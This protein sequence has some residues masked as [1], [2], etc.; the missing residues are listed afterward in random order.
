MFCECR[1][2]SRWHNVPKPVRIVVYV[3]MGLLV[4]SSFALMFGYLTMTLWNAI[5]PKISSL[6]ELTFWQAVGLLVLA[7]LFTGSF[8]HGRCREHFRQK[9]EQWAKDPAGCCGPTDESAFKAKERESQGGPA[10]DDTHG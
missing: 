1:S 6:P 4:A 7:R 2:D 8:S 3:L 10:S 5:L 9:R